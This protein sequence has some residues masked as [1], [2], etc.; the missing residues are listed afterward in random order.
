MASANIV[1]GNLH[2]E[3]IFRFVLELSYWFRSPPCVTV[4]S[5]LFDSWLKHMRLIAEFVSI[6]FLMGSFLTA[7]ETAP[8]DILDTGQTG[9]VEDSGSDSNSSLEATVVTASRPTYTENR[10]E[11]SYVRAS[12]P[13]LNDDSP[14]MVVSEALVVTPS[15]VV[16]TNFAT[17]F[18]TDSITETEL[19]EQSVRS[20]PEAFERTPGV[21]VQKTA[22]GQGSP[23]IRGWTAFHNLFL[24]DGVRLNHAAF[25]SGPN[26][27]WNTV[28]SQGLATIELVK[29]QGSVFYG[30]DAVGG[31]VQ[32]LTRRP[33]YADE[34]FHS[35][36]RSYSRFSSAENSYI[37]R[38]EYSISEV[39]KYG[40]LV[41]GTYKEFGDISAADLG[42]LPFTAYDEWDVDG[43]LEIFLI[44]D[45][46][47]TLFHHQVHIDDA[48]RVHKTRFGRSFSGTSIGDEQARILDQA[49][50]LSYA[51]LD[52]EAD[53]PLFDQY[54]FNLS[55]QQHDEERFR[56]RANGRFEVQGFTLDSYGASVQFDRYLD[57]TDLT[58]GGSYYF[59][60]AASFR[61]DYNID[62]SFRGARIQGPIG[63]EADYH[64]VAGFINTSTPINDRTTIDLGARYTYAATDIGRVEDP[65]TGGPISIEGSWQNV[66]GSG[67]ISHQLDPE[68]RFRLFGGI[69]Q[70]FRAPGF[71]DLSRLDTNRSNEIETPVDTLDPEHFTTYEIGV[72]AHAGDLDATLSYYYTDVSGLILR[73]PTG[74]VIG[75]DLEVTKSN[76]GNGHV[77][78]VELHFEY[79]LNESLR[80]FG[81]FTYQDSHVTTFPTSAPVQSKE[82]LSRLMPLT[83]FGGIRW[84]SSDKCFWLEGTL[85]IADDADRINTRDSRDIQRI[86]PGGTPGYSIASIRSGW[87]VN[88][89]INLTS[90]VENL[91]DEAYRAH[92]S[93]QN[94]PGIN[95]VFGAEV[96]F[97]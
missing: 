5:L 20:V 25:R 79:D 40:L 1:T 54:T 55:H 80:V 28:D 16:E 22:H 37:Q 51:R 27:Y 57:F 84:E 19:M 77:Q 48:W 41:G 29:S 86:P 24:I 36:G 60:T 38:G 53:H 14:A 63:D 50:I 52:G 46:R 69:S 81:G 33:V 73:T 68:D 17:P 30:S 72:K 8:L 43:K 97:E 42:T 83:G 94:E 3:R 35:S 92:G 93:G 12:G 66:V 6:C 87:N 45:T 78:G 71:S 70:G 26:Q 49:R 91:F 64:L 34:G 18:V 10:S 67:R 75:G 13:V 2:N 89:R 11:R 56:K 7:Q 65:A 61:H 32:A 21:L 88:D 23:F 31:T 4:F 95:F 82:V 9:R 85:T 47:L 58:Y 62:G 96:K 59:D 15:R 39:G 74:N 44:E 90:G 76:V